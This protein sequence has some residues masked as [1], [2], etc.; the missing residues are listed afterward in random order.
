MGKGSD[1]ERELA[2]AFSLWWTHN[3]DDTVF[4]RVL[5]SGGR[6][7]RKS[8]TGKG[9]TH[10]S[11]GDLEATCPSGYAFTDQIVC[12]FK[13]GYGRWAIT[14]I[15]DARTIKTQAWHL[16]MEQVLE[17]WKNSERRWWIVVFKRDQRKPMIALCRTL[18]I[19][20]YGEP[21]ASNGMGYRRK[22]FRSLKHGRLY[23]GEMSC[24]LM[25]LDDFFVSVQPEVFI[26]AHKEFFLG[27]PS[28]EGWKE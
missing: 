18:F 24:A 26:N 17:S 11:F 8:R 27:G 25:T 21:S 22:I 14:D 3:T 12:E 5:G 15:L 23:H 19:W 1:F 13:R 16:F 20:L 10:V 9:T 2:R 7:T 28:S 6:A 4:W